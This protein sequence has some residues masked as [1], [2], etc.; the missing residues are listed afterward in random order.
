MWLAISPPIGPGLLLL[1][2]V[3]RLLLGTGL[4]LLGGPCK[5]VVFEGCS[6]YRPFRI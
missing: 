5:R 1:L 4:V 6:C 3:R 2:V